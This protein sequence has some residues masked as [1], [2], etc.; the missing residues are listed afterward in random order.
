MNE[1]RSVPGAAAPPD[2]TTRHPAGQEAY[3]P[4]GPGPMMPGMAAFTWK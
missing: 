2:Q 1:A 3:R 4:S